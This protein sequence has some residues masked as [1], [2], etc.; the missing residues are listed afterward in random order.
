MKTAEAAENE[1]LAN[2]V[3]RAVTAALLVD[4]QV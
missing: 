3:R 1:A 4:D 2:I